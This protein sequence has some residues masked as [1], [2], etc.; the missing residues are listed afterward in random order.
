MRRDILS[1]VKHLQVLKASIQSEEILYLVLVCPVIDVFQRLT[2]LDLTR[3]TDG[4]LKILAA[5]PNLQLKY[6]RLGDLSNEL[7]LNAQEYE[8]TTAK[9]REAFH[10]LLPKLRRLEYLKTW[11]VPGVTNETI[12]LLTDLDLNLKHASLAHSH[13]SLRRVSSLITF[14]IPAD[15]LDPTLLI[16]FRDGILLRNP[17]LDLSELHFIV[18][19]S[20]SRD[21]LLA[22]NTGFTFASV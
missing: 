5:I 19:K 15:P 13:V 11:F 1:S 9:Y 18:Q 14:E 10:Q 2:T 12:Q 17:D 20:E 6:L 21:Q 7:H 22:A 8:I 16:K 3:F 4:V